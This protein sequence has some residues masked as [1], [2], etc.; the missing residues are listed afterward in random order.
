YF[1]ARNRRLTAVRND[2]SSSTT[3]MMGVEEVE[4][5]RVSG[6]EIMTQAQIDSYS[7]VTERFQVS[8]DVEYRVSGVEGGNRVSGLECRGGGNARV[9]YRGSKE[10][11]P[12]Y[13]LS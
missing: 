11:E 4:G 13:Q 9:E 3:W 7:S 1:A 8:G 12:Q 5:C 10:R 2:G 6:V